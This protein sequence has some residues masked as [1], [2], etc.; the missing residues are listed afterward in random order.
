MGRSLPRAVAR[1]IVPSGPIQQRRRSLP[2]GV[3]GH[4]RRS[5]VPECRRYVGVA[6]WENR[7]AQ[8]RRRLLH[9][10]GS[11]ADPDA[12]ADGEDG[13]GVVEGS[14]RANAARH[15]AAQRESLRRQVA[16]FR[17]HDS[18][19]AV[20]RRA[21]HGRGIEQPGEPGVSADPDPLARRDRSL[22]AVRRQRRRSSCD[23]RVAHC[24]IPEPED[25]S[26]LVTDAQGLADRASM[27]VV[28]SAMVLRS[29][30]SLRE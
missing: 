7:N 5:A 10:S 11:I 1:R 8:L 19:Q 17:Q 25:H 18:S 24:D 21:S 2:A 16:R 26:R 15:A 13:G 4:L 23:R 9:R 22:P 28:R 29:L 27:G 6:I 30:P 3:H 12:A 14:S 20:P